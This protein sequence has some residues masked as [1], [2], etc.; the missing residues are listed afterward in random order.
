MA[1][2][3]KQSKGTPERNLPERLEVRITTARPEPDKSSRLVVTEPA[4]LQCFSC[5]SL[6]DAED[7]CEAFDATDPGQVLAGTM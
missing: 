3:R 6:F 2:P 5:G 4:A 1:A 7:R